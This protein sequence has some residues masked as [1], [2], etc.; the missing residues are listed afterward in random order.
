M[1]ETSDFGDKEVGHDWKHALSLGQKGVTWKLLEPPRVPT[2]LGGS[3]IENQGAICVTPK[4]T[5]HDGCWC[6]LGLG[7]IRD[8]LDYNGKPLRKFGEFVRGRNP[9][10]FK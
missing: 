10:F 7:M 9:Q 5:K 1:Y 3:L 8:P 2:V 6:D 4:P